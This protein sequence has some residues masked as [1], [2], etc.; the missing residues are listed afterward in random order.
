[1]DLYREKF[2]YLKDLRKARPLQVTS[3]G[4]FT[5]KIDARTIED[6]NWGREK[7][8]QLFQYLITARNRRAQHKEHIVARLWE[9]ADST[10]GDRDF[11]VALHG[12]NK[13]LEPNRQKRVPS[14]Y[15]LRQGLAYFINTELLWLDADAMENFVKLGNETMASHPDIALESYRMAIDLYQGPYLPTRL[16]DDWCSEER[17]RLQVLAL[18]AHVT[19]AEMTIDQHP[20]E[21]VRL[22]QKALQM[23]ATW[24]D[25]YFIQIRAYLAKGNRPQAIRTYRQCRD[26]LLEEYGIEP[27]PETTRLVEHLL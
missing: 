10:G 15:I 4:G 23:D 22:S 21:S 26:V 9:D 7:T 25:A 6:Q 12:I 11:K 20:M 5:V 1:M 2:N 27:L 17:E 16:Y 18:G 24:E 19:L 13:V 3:L 8:L 14:Q